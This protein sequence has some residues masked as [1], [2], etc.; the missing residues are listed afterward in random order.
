MNDPPQDNGKRNDEPRDDVTLLLAKWRGG[1]DRALET[2]ASVVYNE[3]RRLA[4]RYLDI[5]VDAQD[6]GELQA[7]EV[8]TETLRQLADITLAGTGQVGRKLV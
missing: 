6:V 4:G 3:L 2:L 8:D 1:D 5:L 7:E